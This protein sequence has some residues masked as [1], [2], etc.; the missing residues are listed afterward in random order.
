MSKTKKTSTKYAKISE[1]VT[2]LSYPEKKRSY[3]TDNCKEPFNSK[4][5]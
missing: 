5:L 2:N 4:S 3:L 1:K